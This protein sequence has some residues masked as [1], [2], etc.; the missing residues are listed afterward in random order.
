M[1]H[2]EAAA[3]AGLRRKLVERAEFRSR[4]SDQQARDILAG[5]D[6]DTLETIACWSEN[7]YGEDNE[8]QPRRLSPRLRDELMLHIARHPDLGL[9]WV[10]ADNSS[11]PAAVLRLLLDDKDEELAQTV[12]KKLEEEDGAADE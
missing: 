3:T 12:R 11:V 5:N 6:R 4:L 9:R 10:L 7:F 2:S 1:T 8:D